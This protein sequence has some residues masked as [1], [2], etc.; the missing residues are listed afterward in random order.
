[1]FPELSAGE[2]ARSLD[3]ILIERCKG[4]IAALES[5]AIHHGESGGAWRCS[6]KVWRPWP[7][8]SGCGCY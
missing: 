8:T 1:M 6:P 5:G 7:M 2:D 3:A 4:Y